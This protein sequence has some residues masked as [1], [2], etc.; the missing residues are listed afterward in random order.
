MSQKTKKKSQ[1]AGVPKEAL[2]ALVISAKK[3]YSKYSKIKDLFDNP[4][5]VLQKTAEGMRLGMELFSEMK[6]DFQVGGDLEVRQKHVLALPWTISVPGGDDSD[7]EQAAELQEKFK[8]VYRDLARETLDAQEKGFAVTE[9]N[10]AM[11]DD[12]SVTL[13]SILGHKQDKFKFTSDGMLLMQQEGGGYFPVPVDRV[14]QSTYDKRKGNLYGNSL[15]TRAF[16]PWFFKKHSLL[17]WSQYLEKFGAPTTIGK[18]PAGTPKTQQDLLRECAESIQNDMGIV[19]PDGWTLEFLEAQRSGSAD[20]YE[21]FCKYCDRGISKA[22]LLTT[23]L[24]N[25]AEH[26]TRA[27]ATVQDDIFGKVISADAAWLAQELTRVVQLLALWNFN[28]STPPELIIH[29]EREENGKEE[30]EKDVAI[31][32]ILAIGENYLRKKYDVP[33][34]GK[35]EW[36]VWNGQMVKYGNLKASGG[37]AGPPEEK[38]ENEDSPEFAA[39][40]TVDTDPGDFQF[41]RERDFIDTVFDHN[42]QA[43]MNAIDIAGLEGRLGNASDYPQALAALAG[44]K[45]PQPQ[46]TNTWEPFLNVA[47]HLAEYSVSRQV[48][49]AAASGFAVDIDDDVFNFIDPREAIEWFQ[50]RVSIK[51]EVF[52]LMGPRIKTSAFY[53]SDLQDIALINKVK[54]K[55]ISALKEGKPYRQ[56]FNEIFQASEMLFFG[57]MKNAFHTNMFQALSFQ[58]E[59]ALQRNVARLPWHRYTAAMDNKTRASH[60]A[61]H[62]VVARHDD[63]Y[64]QSWTPPN[65]FFCRCRKV[66]ARKDQVQPGLEKFQTAKTLGFNPDK[67]FQYHPT[68]NNY[69]LLKQLK[70]GYGM[71][72]SQIIRALNQKDLAAVEALEKELAGA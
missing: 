62:G 6:Q 23:L 9:L 66:I 41:I 8:K 26:G 60:A 64:W 55:M 25:E 31:S 49:T 24:T 10:F 63:P 35:D 22:I 7:N 54:L 58:N 27:H 71:K 45:S 57:N 18:Y 5:Q 38:P 44:W 42:T 56:F 33:Y 12:G 19:I 34:P 15:L 68:Q 2:E 11:D 48:E 67:G 4:N 59:Q 40:S 52:E 47:A 37:D 17:F 53:V 13:P 43:I 20:T 72:L 3:D 69:P 61:Q 14:L 16:W 51:K 21:R 70:L 50:R 36:C 30:A 46:S 1:E 39:F 65:G 28:F 29:S 32:K